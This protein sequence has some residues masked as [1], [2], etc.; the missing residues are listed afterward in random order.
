MRKSSVAARLLPGLA[1][2]GVL[3]LSWVGAGRVSINPILQACTYGYTGTPTVSAVSPTSGSTADGFNVVI[4]GTVFCNGAVSVHFGATLSPSVIV[5]SNTQITAT[6]PV[7]AVGLVDVTVTTAG[8]TSATNAGDQFTYVDATTA[9]TTPGL[10]SDLASPQEVDFKI[11]FTATSA[12][13]PSPQYQYF[14]QSPGGAWTLV[15]PWGGPVW[16][17]DTSTVPAIGSFNV[18]VWVRETGAAGVQ[19]NQINPY[20]LTNRVCNSAGLTSDKASPQQIDYTI[21]F[22]ATST[23]CANPAYLYYLQ[24]P[25]G[26]WSIVRGSGGPTFAW[27]TSGLASIGTYHMNVWVT[28]NGSGI[29]VQT[30]FIVTFVI[31][32]RVCSTAG[33]TS[34]KASPQAHGAVITFTATSAACANPS[35]KFYLHTPGTNGVWVVAQNYGGNVLV[36]NT[37]GVAAIGAYEVNVWVT[38]VGSPSAVQTNFVINYTLT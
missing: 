33:M 20:M 37:A 21:T 12:A 2:V 22:T 35:Y 38:A 15:Q 28:A 24:S 3:A 5:N 7:H 9:C 4:T 23:S 27:N 6:A 18:N 30:N 31:T 25:G 14:L 10:G 29:P 17:W 19:V 16:V 1:V 32:D 8:G 11:T 36:W 26:A 13:C 34:D